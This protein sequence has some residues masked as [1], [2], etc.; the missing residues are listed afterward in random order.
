MKKLGLTTFLLIFLTLPVMVLAQE[1]PPA[2]DM[3][4]I[5]ILERIRDWLYSIFLIAA[6][7]FIVIA[8]FTFLTASGDP[9]KFRKA[10]N[11]VLYAL[12]G[13]AIAVASQALV[14]FIRDDIIMP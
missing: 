5:E 4:I 3:D 14:N 7:I 13:V 12:I 8:A 2:E 6:V 9:E 1:A 11:F 10:R